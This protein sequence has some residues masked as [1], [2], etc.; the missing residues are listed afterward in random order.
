MIVLLAVAL[1]PAAAPASPEVAPDPVEHR[2]SLTFDLLFLLA[3]VGE[4]T[5]ELRVEESAVA[6]L[7]GLGAYLELPFREIGAQVRHYWFG[8]FD[9]GLQLGA[10]ARGF[11]TARSRTEYNLVGDATTTIEPATAIGGG[12]FLGAKYTFGTPLTLEAQLGAQFTFSMQDGEPTSQI[13]PLLN[14]NLGWSF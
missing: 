11:Q 3:P 8:D 5:A 2:L 7:L 12:P 10:E 9:R 1:A 4:V 13:A 6:L 14:L